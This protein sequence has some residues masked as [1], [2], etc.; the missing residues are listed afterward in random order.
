VSGSV[1]FSYDQPLLINH[2]FPVCGFP[3]ICTPRVPALGLGVEVFRGHC[4]ASPL[5][6]DFLLVQSPFWSLF[7]LPCTLIINVYDPDYF[8]S[9]S[10][11][12]DN[13]CIVACSV[14]EAGSF[15]LCKTAPLEPNHTH[16][17]PSP[18]VVCQVPDA[19]SCSVSRWLL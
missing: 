2:F 1:I 10:V 3:L 8:L 16:P 7:Y 14:A 17:H 15:I 13:N 18:N 5:P 9:P 11:D 6:D 19:T 12:V 4:G